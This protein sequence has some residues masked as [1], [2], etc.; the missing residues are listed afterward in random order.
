MRFRKAGTGEQHSDDRNAAVDPEFAAIK[1][2][3]IYSEVY[4]E[5]KL[6]ERIILATLTV[7]LPCIGF[8]CTLNAL[9][10]IN[11]VLPETK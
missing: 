9:G 2:R 7:C 1:E 3:L 8:P 5:A 4:A 10:C 11:E 6:R